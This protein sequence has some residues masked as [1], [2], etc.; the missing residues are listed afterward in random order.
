M[1]LR[2]PYPDVVIPPTSLTEF[3]LERAD[4]LGAKPALVDGPSGRTVTYGGLAAAVRRLSAG[5]AERGLRKGDVVAIFA[6]NLPEWPLVFHGIA[7]AGGVITTINSLATAADV[8]QQLRDSSARFLVTVAPFLDRSL[9]AAKSAGVEEVFVIGD[10]IPG[11]TALGDLLRSEATPPEVSID[12]DDL[13]ALPYSSGTTGLPKGVM[14]THRMLIANVL[15]T[16]VLQDVGEDETLIAVLPFF[17]IY[18]MTVIMNLGLRRGATIVT[19]PKFDLE[20]FLELMERH[21]VTRAFLV[22]PIVLALAKHPAVEGRD[23]SA[24]RVIMSGAAPLDAAL[25]EACATRIGCRVMQGYGMTE[26]SPVTH[27][28]SDVPGKTKPGS[29]GELAPNTECRIVDLESGVELGPNLDGELCVRGP[30]VM[31]GYLNSPEATANTIDR[32][33]W[34]HTGDIGHMDETGYF[35]IVDRLKELIKYKGYQVPPA[36]LEAVLLSHPAV[37]D[38]AVIPI[39]DAEAGEVPKAFVVLREPID[40]DALIAYVGARV[41]SYKRIRQVEVVDAIPKSASGKILR[42][43]LVE[44]ERANALAGTTPSR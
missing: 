16:G 36:E 29:I 23:L 25:A 43:V 17:H 33:G 44:Q 39:P 20:P 12:P 18:G 27:I 8:E 6:P 4:R 30:Q 22:P 42:R 2:S 11:A 38:A 13:V 31:R 1:V 40:S 10:A 15:Q 7:A 28:T 9:G 19:M 24:L 41:A 35:Y 32:D 26:T 3:V 21:R 14:L 5:L 34:L 37:S